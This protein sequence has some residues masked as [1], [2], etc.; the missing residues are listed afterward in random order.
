[1]TG[2]QRKQVRALSCLQRQNVWPA[3]PDE[4]QLDPQDPED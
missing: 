4:P 3:D 2:R 1:M